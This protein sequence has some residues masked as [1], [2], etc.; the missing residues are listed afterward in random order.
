MSTHT[1]DELVEQMYYTS[2]PV[3][4]AEPAQSPGATPSAHAGGRPK[5]GARAGAPGSTG[6]RHRDLRLLLAVAR[7]LAERNR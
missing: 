5:H 7:L 3:T 6:K 2:A 1:S 4:A